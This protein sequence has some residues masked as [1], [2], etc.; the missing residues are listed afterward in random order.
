MLL[1]KQAASGLHNWEAVVARLIAESPQP[2][3]PSTVSNVSDLLRA[4]VK[5]CPIPI[6]EDFEC[7]R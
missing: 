7:C 6:S 1:E 3:E 4:I 5:G 2:F